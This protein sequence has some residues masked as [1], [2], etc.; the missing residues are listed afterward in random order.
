MSTPF[1]DKNIQQSMNR[2]ILSHHGKYFIGKFTAN[3]TLNHEMM[4][5][6]P[7]RLRTGQGCLLSSFIFNILLKVLARE[8][9]QEK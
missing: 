3:I 2:I 5:A 8:I 7:L 1:S 4:K 6:F 9:G